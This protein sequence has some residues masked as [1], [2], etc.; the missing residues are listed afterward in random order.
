MMRSDVKVTGDRRERTT[1]GVRVH[2]QV[3]QQRHER[4]P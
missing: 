3:R 4:T 1:L 2:R